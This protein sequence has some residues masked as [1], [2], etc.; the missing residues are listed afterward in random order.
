MKGTQQLVNGFLRELCTVPGLFF[1]MM[2]V[3]VTLRTECDDEI[4]RPSIG[5]TVDVISMF[6]NQFSRCFH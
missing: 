4:V 6:V 1:A 3:L 2:H 5:N